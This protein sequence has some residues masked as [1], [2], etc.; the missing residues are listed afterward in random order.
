MLPIVAGFLAGSAHVV[1]GPDHLAALAPIALDA[2]KSARSLG[3]RWGVG[4]GFGVLLLGGLGILTK[5]SLD[6]NVISA[7]SEFA[8]GFILIGV[9]L[10]SF[11]KARGIVIHSHPHVHSDSIDDHNHVHIHTQTE[12]HTHQ[13][14]Q[15]H[16]HTAFWVG[17][18]HGS[19]GGGHL[20]GVLPSLALSPVD[21]CLYLSS[22]FIAAVISMAIFATVLGYMSSRQGPQVL[23][24]LMYGV[25]IL[26][27][28]LGGVWSYHAWP[29]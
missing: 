15:G 24:K 18:L 25:S 29:L 1:S 26:V 8:V 7:W 11:Y 2:P 13:T 4:H 6:L 5:E 22:Y 20:L 9:G 14:H 21:A 10:W 23:Q 12:E 16:A 19:A 17:M 27:L 3:I 28:G